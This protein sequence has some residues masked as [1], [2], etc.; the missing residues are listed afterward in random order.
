MPSIKRARVEKRIQ[1]L[2][3]QILLRELRDPRLG[4]LTVTRVELA[5]DYREAKVFVSVMGDDA[6]KRT[7]LRALE[8]S[9]GYVQQRIAPRL[10]IRSLPALRFELDRAV[11]KSLR[12]AEILHQIDRERKEREEAKSDGK[13]GAGDGQEERGLETKPTPGEE[14]EG[15]EEEGE[16]GGG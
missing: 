4:F 2:V 15:E 16:D 12:M 10:A 1:T 14:E 6:Q 8:D 3:S 9:R 11:D 7:S 13:Q 5:R